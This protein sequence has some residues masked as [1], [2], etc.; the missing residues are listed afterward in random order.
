MYCIFIFSLRWS[1][2]SP[3][4]SQ[5]KLTRRG[6]QEWLCF[7]L[8]CITSSVTKILYWRT[9]FHIWYSGEDFLYFSAVMQDLS[10][11]RV[12]FT[13]FC[14]CFLGRRP[15]RPLC[16]LLIFKTSSSPQSIHLICALV[17]WLNGVERPRSTEG[18]IKL[19]TC[20][21]LSAHAQGGTRC[22]RIRIRMRFRIRVLDQSCKCAKCDV[23]DVRAIK[24]WPKA[25]QLLI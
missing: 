14:N 18:K 17:W 19:P 13:T 25:E 9:G 3:S 12:S 8:V 1:L 11:F 4:E 24:K 10:H 20:L 15:D 21:L 22:L 7:K 23:M 6:W 2:Q 5:W 16:T